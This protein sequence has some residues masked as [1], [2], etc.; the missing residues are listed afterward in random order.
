M[1]YSQSHWTDDAASP[2]FTTVIRAI[3]PAGNVNHVLAEACKMMQS[4]KIPAD[5][6]ELL[7]ANVGTAA[8]YDQAIAY[9]EAW[10]PV[11]RE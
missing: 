11:E 7:R 6:I 5:R 3:G 4:L 9:I 8:S 1:T 10:F 2:V